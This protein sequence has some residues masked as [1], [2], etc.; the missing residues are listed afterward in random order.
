MIHLSYKIETKDI[1]KIVDKLILKQQID[2]VCK[3]TFHRSYR[4]EMNQLS[5][6][7]WFILKIVA[8]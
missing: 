6:L 5:R 1:C 2:I 8:V 3:T 7:R 4:L